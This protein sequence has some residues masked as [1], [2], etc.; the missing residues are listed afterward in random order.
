MLE[1]RESVRGWRAW[2]AAGNDWVQ[3]SESGGAATTQSGCGAAQ[4]HCLARLRVLWSAKFVPQESLNACILTSWRSLAALD[5]QPSPVHAC[6]AE[7]GC[8]IHREWLCR[9]VVRAKHVPPAVS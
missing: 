1:W 2:K 4:E 7:T 5:E 6:T 3:R 9:C 8:S